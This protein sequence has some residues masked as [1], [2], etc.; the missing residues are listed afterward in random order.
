MILS[1]FLRK[2]HIYDKSYFLLK[3]LLD[4]KNL[5]LLKTFFYYGNFQAFIKEERK[6]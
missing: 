1:P 6:V 2:A 3:L 4:S 5:G